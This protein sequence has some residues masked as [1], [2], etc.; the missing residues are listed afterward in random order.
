[1]KK[2]LKLFLVF[3]VAFCLT[4]NVNAEI[5]TREEAKELA[6]KYVDDCV[7]FLSKVD[8]YITSTDLDNIE[9]NLL[10]L[11]EN[12]DQL[13]EI[14]KKGLDPEHIINSLSVIIDELDGGQFTNLFI[15]YEDETVL[16]NRLL[17]E[18]KELRDYFNSFEKS[19]KNLLNNDA[20]EVFKV[21][22]DGL[23]TEESKTVSKDVLNILVEE[24]VFRYKYDLEESE[25]LEDIK[26]S[27]EKFNKN[28]ETL[29][30]IINDLYKIVDEWQKIYDDYNI[31][32][33]EGFLLIVTKDFK[34]DLINEVNDLANAITSRIIDFGGYTE[35]NQ[36]MLSKIYK[37]YTK[38]TEELIEHVPSLFKESIKTFDDTF[39]Q[40][41]IDNLNVE[42]INF[43]STDY[44]SVTL[45]F[46]EVAIATGYKIAYSTKEFTNTV[47]GSFGTTKI[48]S[49]VNGIVT[50][51]ITGLTIDKEYYLR[52]VP[53]L[54]V[55]TK[56]KGKTKST[57]YYGNEE[58]ISN[59]KTD[60]TNLTY[61][62]ATPKLENVKNLKVVPNT[63]T[64]L[65]LSW[66]K[67]SGATAYSIFECDGDNC[68]YIASITKTTYTDKGR[69]YTK[70]V[71]E[72]KKTV[73]KTFYDGLELGN[74]Y[75]YKVVAVRKLTVNKK[76][77]YHFS[78]L[79][80]KEDNTLLD[81]KK[82]VSGFST[83]EKELVGENKVSGT[84][85]PII[86]L[87]EEVMASSSKV[88]PNALDAKFETINS[89]DGIVKVNV[90]KVDY[91][92]GTLSYG[93]KVTLDN[94]V[95][96][97]DVFEEF[98]D[99]FE[100]NNLL[101]GKTY[102]ITIIPYLT[103][104]EVKVAGTEKVYKYKTISAKV[105][106]T[107]ETT[108]ESYPYVIINMDLTNQ[109]EGTIV[110]LF[111]STNNKSW[112]TV[113][114]FTVNGDNFTYTDT[115]TTSG[116]KKYYYRVVTSTDKVKNKKTKKYT[117]NNNSLYANTTISTVLDK[118]LNF[119]IE[120]V[121]YNQV[122]L[123]WDKVKG[124]QGYQIYRSTTG[125]S[126]SF[127]KVATVTDL[128]Y[129]DSKFNVGQKYYYCVRAYYKVNKKTTK[130][131]SFSDKVN[132]ATVLNNPV[133]NEDHTFT[134]VE[135]MTSYIIYN[136]SN[137]VIKTIALTDKDKELGKVV[138]DYESLGLKYD[139]PIK[140]QAAYKYSYKSGSK[141][142]SF[143]I[144]SQIV[145]VFIPIF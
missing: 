103:I 61:I 31:D 121:E 68:K 10:D 57:T 12:N 76:A 29:E 137:E 45:E 80:T 72:K 111:R 67:V 49:N 2:Y 114:E 94:E 6:S 23:N 117:Y 107:V 120:Q 98:K 54:T 132:L 142:K 100:I 79:F 143:T 113:K 123:A 27:I 56:V 131:G 3:I 84:P 13:K 141:K 89:K 36:A 136:D 116:T 32:D 7:D 86:K 127:S 71:K 82:S 39:K 24:F 91:E 35:E 109:K 101:I 15:E 33:Q 22:K 20:V 28:Y 34:D 66:D 85:R 105:N 139:T 69:S 63:V 17:E 30:L 145:N 4:I 88:G 129:T 44:N 128:E 14:S 26:K 95:I 140:V 50:A 52:V 62:K 133:S 58:T 130:Y 138:I 37:L 1:M 104:N 47:K 83:R 19:K 46:P 124:A 55:K 48:I 96:V 74:E 60:V 115:K 78:S 125:K 8:D 73:T 99:E 41:I 108:E 75:T 90:T 112:T 42:Y 25:T 18:G 11:E 40:S 16:L 5:K 51:K 53:Y 9:Y 102:E 38:H 135:G 81:A 119:T 106:Y 21:I 97:E 93:Y 118:V 59:K 134:I 77:E 110:R 64:S 92:E 87:D 144:K 70:K 122:K 65:K 126:G 43:V